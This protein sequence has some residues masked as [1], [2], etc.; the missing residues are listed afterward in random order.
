MKKLLTWWLAALP[1]LLWAQPPIKVE[2]LV[3]E[4]PTWKNQEKF[5]KPTDKNSLE[6]VL[7]G[8]PSECL[9]W[10]VHPGLDYETWKQEENK[11][12]R[13]EIQKQFQEGKLEIE[14]S[15]DVTK[16]VES[17][18]IFLQKG[19]RCI[20]VDTTRG[21][22]IDEYGQYAYEEVI[23]INWQP[24]PNETKEIL[25]FKCYK[26]E[27]DFRGRHYIVW[28]CPDLPYP[29]G[30]WKLHGLPG[31]ILEAHD[32]LNQVNFIVKRIDIS[33]KADEEVQQ[34]IASFKA[35]MK[36]PPIEIISQEEL[37]NWFKKHTRR[38]LRKDL[39][40][41]VE[42]ELDYNPYREQQFYEIVKE[43]LKAK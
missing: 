22:G 4:E 29:Y 19:G 27:G 24:Y 28:Y 37:L 40:Q 12:I 35:W 5:P 13:E 18:G 26:A 21:R 16:L 38:K 30:P 14:V 11:R 6:A 9:Y 10:E 33:A 41:G 42:V 8:L 2:Y 7:W 1:A 39:A 20:D 36:K 43:V 34:K 17:R 15:Y 23:Q 3:I 25:G 32:D 31:L